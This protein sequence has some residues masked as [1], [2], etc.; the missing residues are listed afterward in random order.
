MNELPPLRNPSCN[1]RPSGTTKTSMNACSG[2]VAVL[3][4][5]TKP[6]VLLQPVRL[7]AVF[8]EVFSVLTAYVEKSVIDYTEIANFY[9]RKI[10]SPA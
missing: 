4:G 8:A 7:H 9:S 2:S 10:T 1:H 6:L 5:L 3:D